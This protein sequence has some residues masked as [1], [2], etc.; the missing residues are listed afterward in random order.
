[1]ALYFSCSETSSSSS[2]R[3]L[4][5]FLNRLL[6]E[7]GS[8]LRLLQLGAQSLDLLLVGLL[9]L[10][11]LLLS[12]LERLEVVGDNP[13]LLLQLEDLGL[14]HVGAL[15][16]LLQLGLAGGQL[17]RNLIVVS[18]GG[19]SLLPGLLEL[20][21]QSGDPLLVLVGLALEH[22]LGTLGVVGSSGGLVE[23]GHG[24]HHL[25]LGLLK[26]LLEAGHP[27]VQGVHLELAGGQ[28]LLLL[29]QLEGGN[30]EL[31]GSE[32]QL[33][34]QLPRL[35]HQLVHLVLGLGRPQLGSFALLLANVHA[36]A[37]VVLLHLHSLHLLFDGFH[38]DVV[39]G[40]SVVRAGS[41]DESR[42]ARGRPPD[43]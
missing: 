22:L 5:K 43:S 18:V 14:T 8:C 24:G 15:L 17:L 1:M 25:L 9:P 11:R 33:G 23:L 2:L 35:R 28:L 32:V 36:V 27:P 37:G 34:L 16:R 12:Y 10:V 19:L 13:Q 29:L 41:R 20:L 7:L 39:G 4:L 6:C 40:G 38:G 42:L 3:L 31:L 21:L 30:A 26:V